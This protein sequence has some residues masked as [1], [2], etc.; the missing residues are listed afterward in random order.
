MPKELSILILFKLPGS[1]TQQ[2]AHLKL[3]FSL[4]ING[5]G[6]IYLEANLHPLRVCFLSI[7]GLAVGPRE[8]ILTFESILITS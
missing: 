4:I 1:P 2:Q 3:F 5:E 6:Y 7:D 8:T